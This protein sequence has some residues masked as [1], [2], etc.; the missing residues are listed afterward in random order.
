MSF[1][2]VLLA[3]LIATAAVVIGAAYLVS[4]LGPTLGGL[5]AGT[6]IIMAPG[7]VFLIMEYE[8]IFSV[9]AAES[10]LYALLG[11]LTFTTFFVMTVERLGAWTSLLLASFLWLL[12]AIM[13][14][15]LSW[16]ALPAS[17]LYIIGLIA[18]QRLSREKIERSPASRPPFLWYEIIA[19][20][21]L[22]GF[23]VSVATTLATRY[24]PFVSGLLLG[25]PV[26]IF[27]VGLTIYGRSGGLAARRT[28][29][30]AQVGMISLVAFS[31]AIYI[32]ADKLPPL[33]S[34]L[35]SIGVSLLFSALMMALSLMQ[36]FY[37]VRDL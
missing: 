23:L 4:R 1:I 20:G 26:G 25:Y 3:K 22:A 35:V 17:V 30:S 28:V 24:D 33:A 18:T 13:L 32:T 27:T 11:T 10:T 7:Y 19:R 36:R 2:L 21:L 34:I 15:H 6:P 16:G 14:T 5:A 37:K 12:I 9:L 8:P 31:L 29:R